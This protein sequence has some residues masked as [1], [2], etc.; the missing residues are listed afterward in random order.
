MQ[1]RLGY[2]EICFKLLKKKAP[3]TLFYHLF[4]ISYDVNSFS[5]NT[6]ETHADFYM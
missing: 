4:K 6:L 1:I 2:H 3:N 5:G